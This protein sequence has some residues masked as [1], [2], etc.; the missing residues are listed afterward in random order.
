MEG[1]PIAA[2]NGQCGQQDEGVA[3]GGGAG[4]RV[5]SERRKAGG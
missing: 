4:G 3:G 2:V 5:A 1:V